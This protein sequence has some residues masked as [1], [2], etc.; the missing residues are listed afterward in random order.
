MYEFAICSSSQGGDERWQLM[1]KLDLNS[2]SC[3]NLN[4]MKLVLHVPTKVKF[5]IR[6]FSLK[7][8]VI[9][10]YVMSILR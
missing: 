8:R 2:N 3:D 5:S 6:A 1:S 10:I 7:I 4:N 9:N